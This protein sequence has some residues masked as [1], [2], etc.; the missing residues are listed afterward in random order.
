MKLSITLVTAAAVLSVSTMAFAK[1]G[2]SSSPLLPNTTVIAGN[3]SNNEFYV[4]PT[5]NPH[6][7]GPVVSTQKVTQDNNKKVVPMLE[8]ALNQA[9]QKA[10]QVNHQKTLP[11]VALNKQKSKKV[12]TA[13]NVKPHH[14]GH[15][16]G[17][18]KT[19]VAATKPIHHAKVKMAS[20]QTHHKMK[21]TT[22]VK[23]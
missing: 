20:N 13:S 4:V 12:I 23:I 5:T 21:H 15:Q 1:S 10:H 17:V 8:A 16:K 9:F 11:N 2:I 14:V 3:L 6:E 19:T 18:A 7:V 22:M